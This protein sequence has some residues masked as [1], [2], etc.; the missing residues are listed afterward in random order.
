MA[1]RPVEVIK[2]AREIL[3]GLESGR[4]RGRSPAG[5]PLAP[6]ERGEA[7]QMSLFEETGHELAERIRALPLDEMTPLDAMNILH[8]LQQELE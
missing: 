3:A 1:G 5:V 7:R 2:R 6:L 4:L 8:D